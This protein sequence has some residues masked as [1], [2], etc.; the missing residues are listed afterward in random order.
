MRA[1]S[2]VFLAFLV[3][4]C[5]PKNVDPLPDV[6]QVKSISIK[7][8]DPKL[9]EVEFTAATEDW[10]A[11]RASLLPA[12]VDEMPA[13]WEWAASVDLTLMD[14][15]PFRVELYTPSKGSGAFAAGKTF[16]SRVYYRGGNTA[17]M[18]KAVTAAFN[19]SKKTED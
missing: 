5:A 9:D 12:H 15:Q 8:D 6:T 1:A 3:T 10:A 11:I 4:S 16:K 7:F 19:R 18:L 17:A 14:G 2:V 13:S